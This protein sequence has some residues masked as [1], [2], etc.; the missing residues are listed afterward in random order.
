MDS[1]R[2]RC[3]VAAG[4]IRLKTAARRPPARHPAACGARNSFDLYFPVRVVDLQ[5]AQ[6]LVHAHALLAHAGH[7]GAAVRAYVPGE[8]HQPAA[9]MAALLQLRIAVGT[10]LPVILDA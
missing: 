6:G 9:V 5:I 1:M 2:M 7:R 8:F 10:D 3:S 4:P